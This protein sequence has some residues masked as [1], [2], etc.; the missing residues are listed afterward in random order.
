MIKNQLK[1]A[2]L[3]S[4]LTAL[5][6]W[7]GSLFGKAGLIIGLAFA[8]LI[9]FGS[10]FFSHKIV[11]W[12]YKA[13]EIKKGEHEDLAKMVKDLA[14][15]AGMPMPQLYI[16][17][18]NTPNAFATGRNP[19]HAVVA[20]TEGILKVLSKEEL[21]GVLAHELSHVKNRDI[22]ITTIAATIAGVISYVAAMARWSAILGGGNNREGNNN[23]I[24]L[25]VI[26]I[27]TPIIALLV[28]LA[29]S[30]SREYLADESGAK[31][32]KDGEPLASALE[33]IEKNVAVSPLGFGNTATS[34]LFI[35]NPFRA[36][37][38]I[39]LLS[40]HPPTKE[41]AKRLRSL[42]L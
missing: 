36:S 20:C 9:N 6:L 4:V 23:I 28:Q 42:R 31:L 19:K 7:V 26:G 10:Y 30:R 41:R 16:V 3:L 27:I 32:I 11:L 5:L 12:M 15:K 33:K 13:R 34:S 40:T 24:S 25:L 37:A 18:S 21:K 29:I 14:E 1:T 35:V 22:L 2:V 8:L 17:P 38:F 39:H